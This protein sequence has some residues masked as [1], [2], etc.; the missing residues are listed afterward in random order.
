MV[1]PLAERYRGTACINLLPRDEE[2]DD[3]VRRNGYKRERQDWFPPRGWAQWLHV[4]DLDDIVLRTVVRNAI[5][6]E[7]E[8]V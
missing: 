6:N 7:G 5:I 3:R 2:Y 8:R 1:H 4:V